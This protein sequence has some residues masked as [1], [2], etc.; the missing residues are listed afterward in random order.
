MYSGIAGYFLK[1]KHDFHKN[2]VTGTIFHRK[3]KE[4]VKLTSFLGLLTESEIMREGQETIQ[5]KQV[6]ALVRAE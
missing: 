2:H 5:A 4:K 1:F 6:V 3:A